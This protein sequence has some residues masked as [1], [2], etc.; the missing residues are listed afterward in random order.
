MTI[1][2]AQPNLVSSISKPKKAPFPI[3]SLEALAAAVRQM[4]AREVRI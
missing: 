2:A 1:A 3:S 4:Q